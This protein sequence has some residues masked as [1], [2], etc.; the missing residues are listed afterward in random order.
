MF[1]IA[2]NCFSSKGECRSTF[3]LI[4]Y[5]QIIVYVRD[6]GFMVYKGP[7]EYN[8]LDWYLKTLQKPLQRIDT[9]DEFTEFVLLNDVIIFHLMLIYTI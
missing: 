7:F 9:I 5:P 2:V 8:Y 3:N 6:I 4:R 1:F